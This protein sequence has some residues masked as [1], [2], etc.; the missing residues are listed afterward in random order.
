MEYRRATESD[1]VAIAALHADSWRRHYRGTYPDE[2]LDGPVDADRLEVWSERFAHMDGSTCTIV[3]DDSGKLVGFAHTIFDDDPTWG[4]LVDNLHV[5]FGLKGQGVGTRLLSETAAAV[6]ERDPSGA[7]FLWV[8]EANAAAQGFYAALGGAHV[9][10]ADL[11]SVRGGTVSSLR[12]AWADPSV[13]IVDAPLR[14][15]M[16]AG[17]KD[18]LRGR[19][20]SA[21]A[22]LRT[23]L[24]AIANAEAV[25]PA[26]PTA[27]VGLLADVERRVLTEADVRAIVAAERA[28]LQVAID[29]MRTLGQTETAGELA[30]R[31]A[32]LDLY[33]KSG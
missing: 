21:V 17:L 10:T 11:E 14:A 25:D 28:E 13:L 18:A 29:E 1:A 16:E 26:A 33:L 2:Y 27:R 31:A 7:L 23:T 24:A 4:S 9:E 22:V 3:A 30:Q 8:L 6:V 19:D 20:A 5:T 32:T 12:I 15:R